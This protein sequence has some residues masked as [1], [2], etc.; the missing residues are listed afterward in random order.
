MGGWSAFSST[1]V[2]NPSTDRGLAGGEGVLW[3]SSTS[4]I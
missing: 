3:S 4:V 1:E 2:M